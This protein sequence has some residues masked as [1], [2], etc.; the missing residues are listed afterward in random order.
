VET[1][2]YTHQLHFW[3]PAHGGIEQLPAALNKRVA[4]FTPSF[5]VNSIRKVGSDWHVSNGVET[6]VYERLV[7]TIPLNTMARVVDGVP[8]SVRTATETLR[9]NSLMTVTLGVRS[10]DAPQFT[11]VYVP[12][13]EFIFHRISFP[14]VFS[15]HNAPEG[16]WLVQ[17]EVTGFSGQGAFAM[18]DRCI[19]E[20]VTADLTKMGMIDPRNVIYSRVIT[21]DHGYVV[22]D[23]NCARNLVTARDY[24]E[25]D[26]EIRLC[27][28]VA[29]FEYINMDQCMQRA[30]RVA[31]ELDGC[32]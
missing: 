19:V 27:G 23:F 16:T 15:P 13:P 21:C 6:R 5:V 31:K 18:S 11:A 9:Y 14:A 30:M 32:L 29:E 8:E 28:R 12:A 22:R 2:G 24:F 4:R 25:K 26:L 17:A 7:C 1:E 3:Y 10:S 20:R